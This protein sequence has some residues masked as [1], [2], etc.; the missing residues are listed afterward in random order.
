MIRWLRKK[1]GNNTIQVA[2]HNIKYLI[3]TLTKQVKDMYERTSSPRVKKDKSSEDGKTSHA[4]GSVGLTVKIDSL[5][6]AMI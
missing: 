3:V 5:P 6:K 2:T 4:Q 1:L